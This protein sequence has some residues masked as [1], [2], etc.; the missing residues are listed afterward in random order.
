M[1]ALVDQTVCYVHADAEAENWAD[2][3]TPVGI[4]RLW[5]CTDCLDLLDEGQ[6][7][8]LLRSWTDAIEHVMAHPDYVPTP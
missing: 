3:D 8:K 6:Q 7:P 1:T 5:L 4:A 2:F